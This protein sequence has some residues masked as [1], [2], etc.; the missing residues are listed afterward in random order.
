MKLNV[1]GLQKMPGATERFEFVLEHIDD[2]D[3]IKFNK[4]VLVDGK[5]SNTGLFLELSAHISTSVL[6][7]CCKCLDEV[8]IP[9]ELDFTEQYFHESEKVQPESEGGS[10]ATVLEY[11]DDLIDL[12]QAVRDNIV[13][14]LPMRILCT[15][16]CP[17][18]CP[19]CGRSLKEGPCQCN[20]KDID[21]RLA[22]LAQL[23]K[24]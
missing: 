12:E 19:H 1:S 14:S 4:P 7:F 24:E 20:T 21:P 15:P 16:K 5:I 11:N 2:E 17:G 22:V 9:I 10:E 6:A 13:I 18:L 8:I 23:K 3:D